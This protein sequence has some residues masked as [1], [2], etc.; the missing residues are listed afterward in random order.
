[1]PA[2]SAP[3]VIAIKGAGR[4]ASGAAVGRRLIIALACTGNRDEPASTG[5]ST[6]RQDTAVD[7][8]RRA[9]DIPAGANTA[10]GRTDGHGS[11]NAQ[12]IGTARV[13]RLEQLNGQGSGLSLGP[14]RR[15][16]VPAVLLQLLQ[17]ACVK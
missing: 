8:M 13:V 15:G 12:M 17:Q 10:P 9:V 4:I 7:R 2:T 5:E 14:I 1:M 6:L 11:M 3:A 16:S